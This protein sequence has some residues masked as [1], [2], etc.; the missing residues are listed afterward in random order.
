MSSVRTNICEQIKHLIITCI[1]KHSTP[2][3]TEHTGNHF[4]VIIMASNT[5]KF[6]SL[7]KACSR[8]GKDM[9]FFLMK[10]I[11]EYISLYVKVPRRNHCYSISPSNAKI[12]IPPSSQNQRDREWLERTSP[13]ANPALIPD[14]Q[15]LPVSPNTCQEILRCGQSTQ[16]LFSGNWGR[17]NGL[18]IRNKD[19]DQIPLI[20]PT[21][22]T[23]AH[24]ISLAVSNQ[25][26]EHLSHLTFEIT[27]IT[28]S[29]ENLLISSDELPEQ[30]DKPPQTKFIE[31]ANNR[32]LTN[33]D[34]ETLLPAIAKRA[35]HLHELIVFSLET[36]RK[37]FKDKDQYP[38]NKAVA[39]E[40]MKKKRDYSMKT[41]LQL[42]S[43]IRPDA[44]GRKAQ[45]DSER[46]EARI[47]TLISSDLWVLVHIESR[48]ASSN[49]G[50]DVM[51]ELRE[52]HGFGETKAIICK[53]LFR[54]DSIET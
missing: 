51:R 6:I 27:P 12:Y 22:H 30:G 23:R 25:Y 53:K 21:H 14:V 49:A 44:L 43:I 29:S 1:A 13:Y 31:S 9:P 39:E 15:Y 40:L 24:P 37:S 46:E 48:L 50:I 2:I 45:P 8:T 41:A 17:H 32:S 34:I 20:D 7:K 47:N 38:S 54:T 42:A 10:A 35:P 3:F 16:I 5:E 26:G 33:S 18:G 4:S 36:W 11:N 52:V 28:V 19:T